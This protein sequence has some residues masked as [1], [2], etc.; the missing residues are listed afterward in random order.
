MIVR[1]TGT[2]F[3][4]PVAPSAVMVMFVLCVPQDSPLMFTETVTLSV[5]PVEEPEGGFSESHGALSLTLQLSVPSPQ[6][7]MLR[8]LLAG[9]DPPSVA[10]KVKEV[11]DRQRV[12]SVSPGLT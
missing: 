1:E 3:G 4:L 11:G 9:L 12:G 8:V 7:Q 6:F 5:S 10:E 2:V